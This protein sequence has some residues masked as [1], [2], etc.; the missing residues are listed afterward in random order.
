MPARRFMFA[1]APRVRSRGAA[2]DRSRRPRRL[3]RAHRVGSLR[4]RNARD[5]VSRSRARTPTVPSAMRNGSNGLATK[6]AAPAA[7]SS[8]RSASEASAVRNTTGTSAVRGSLFSSRHVAA[9]SR[10]GMRPSST[11]RS[12]RSAAARSIASRPEDTS[13]S[14]TSG[15]VPS[16]SSSRRR[17][18]ASSSAARMRIEEGEAMNEHSLRRGIVSRQRSS[19]TALEDRARDGA[20][21]RRAAA[22][23]RAARLSRERGGARYAHA[24]SVKRCASAASARRTPL[25]GRPGGDP[26]LVAPRGGGA[27]GRA[28]SRAWATPE[29][30]RTLLD[31]PHPAVQSAAT[32]GLAPLVDP[33]TVGQ[34]LDRL[35]GAADG[36][37]PAAVRAARGRSSAHRARSPAATR[38]GRTAAPAQELDR[39][40]R[41]DRQPGRCSR[42]WRRCMAI[43][44]R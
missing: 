25:A 9:P 42:A 24:A 40:R 15:V 10:S 33:T 34:L 17:T 32:S 26:A 31:D 19:D 35:A 38:G 29:L 1:S 4:A 43:P 12:N 39:P 2:P 14:E 13:V 30:L 36:G 27:R 41:S 11:M 44:I 23:R 28:T 6:P 16:E 22:R 37:A 8:S 3:P 20:R 5:G 18:S 7:R 21:R